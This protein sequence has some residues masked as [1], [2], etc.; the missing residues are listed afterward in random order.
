MRQARHVECQEGFANRRTRFC[1]PGCDA[2]SAAI[3]SQYTSSSTSSVSVRLSPW[4]TWTC[5][6]G[7]TTCAMLQAIPNAISCNKEAMSWKVVVRRAMP[8]CR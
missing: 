8:Q 5:S 6:K 2:C 4:R 7:C 1:R 3:L